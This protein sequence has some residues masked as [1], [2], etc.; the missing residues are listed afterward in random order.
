MRSGSTP[1]VTSASRTAPEMAMKRPTRRPYFRRPLGMN[2]TRRVTTSGSVLRPITAA[3]AMAC[4]RAS[5][6]WIKS[7]F[8]VRSTARTR[9]AA[10][11][12]QSPR[13]RT[14]AAAIPAE[15]SRRMSGASGAAMTSGSC[16]ISRWPRARRY[17]WRC[18]PRHSRPESRCNR[19]NE[20]GVVTSEECPARPVAATR[21]W[22][23]ELQ[24]SGPNVARVVPSHRVST[25]P[26]RVPR[27][28]D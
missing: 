24:P 8:Q 6:A 19:R 26:R 7:A 12:S 4:A 11:R 20:G 3:S 14:A 2:G 13:I 17:T 15:R 9:L 1:P 5:C 23:L 10:A 16:P 27:R 18:P 22:W 21:A 28:A 25:P